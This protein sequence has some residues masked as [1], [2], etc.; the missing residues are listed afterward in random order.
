MNHVP[1]QLRRRFLKA[2]CRELGVVWP[3]LSALL[4][5]QVALGFI[6][7]YLETWSVGEAAYFTFVTGL[8]IGYGDLTP[9]RLATRALAILIGFIGILLTGLFAAVGVSA[10]QNARNGGPVR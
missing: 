7:G 1:A 9:S 5:L 4:G 10:L 8:T 2:F 3:I 6:I